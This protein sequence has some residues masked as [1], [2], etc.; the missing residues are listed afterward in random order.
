MAINKKKLE[1]ATALLSKYYGIPRAEDLLSTQALQSMTGKSASGGGKEVDKLVNTLLANFMNS[2]SGALTTKSLI[3][4]LNE[5]VKDNEEAKNRLND[6][7]EIYYKEEDLIDGTTTKL[8]DAAKPLRLPINQILKSEGLDGINTNP[9]SKDDTNLSVILSNSHRLSLTNKDI[10]PAVIFLNGI[11]SVELARAVPFVKVE[12]LFPRPPIGEG[13]RIQTLSLVKFLEGSAKVDSDSSVL[14]KMVNSARIDKQNSNTGEIETYSLAG[15]EL[16]TTPQTMVNANISSD[17]ELHSAQILDKFRPLMTLQSFDVT[18]QPSTGLM[19]FKSADLKFVLH[20]RSRL[21]EI[22]EFVRP[23]LY[24]KTEIQIE[25]GWSYPAGTNSPYGDLINGLRTTEKFA[26][27]NS[28]F[29]FDDVGQVNVTLK[30]AMKGAVDFNNESIATSHNDSYGTMIAGIEELQKIVG[31][32]KERIFN[33]TDS[34]RSKEIRGVQILDLAQDALSQVNFNKEVKG[35]L[36]AF[37]KELKKSKNPSAQKLI[38]TL[39]KIFGEKG[40]IVELRKTIQDGINNKIVKLQATGTDPF[41][42]TE[43]SAEKKRGKSGARNVQTAT[44]RDKRAEAAYKNKYKLPKGITTGTQVSLAKIILSFMSEPLISTKKFDEVQFVFYPFNEHAG[45]AGDLNI[46]NFSVNLEYFTQEFQK[47]RLNHVSKSGKLNLREFLDFLAD[48]V[49]DDPA[50]PSYGLHDEKGSLYKTV[51]NEDGTERSVQM[52]DNPADY[53]TRLEKILVNHGGTFK[54]PQVD[55]YIESLTELTG[56][57]EGSDDLENTGLTI[58]RI[59]IF[60]RHSTSYNSLGTLLAAARESEIEALN[61]A[62]GGKFLIGNDG[63]VAEKEKYAKEIIQAASN[64]SLI[65]PIYDSKNSEI[66]SYRIKGGPRELKKFIMEHMPYII[67]GTGGTTVKAAN[68]S[69]I[70]D[71]Q[72]ST[73]NLLRSFNKSEIQPNGENPGGLPMRII[74]TELTMTTFGNPL[75]NFA[76]QFFIDFQTGTTA[77]A[78]YAVTGLTHRFAPGEFTSEI[79]F[80]PLDGWGRYMSLIE[81]VR[82]AKAILEDTEKQAKLPTTETS[83]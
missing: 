31:D 35:E 52:V 28:S 37:T 25:Y 66:I 41:L 13:N 46:G 40:K 74:P 2:S 34:S 24:G 7:F 53:Q 22:A 75:I 69:S 48:V 59:H 72:L 83:V 63:V 80:S 61:N 11:P 58:L 23:D 73:I 6:I 4:K 17:P 36:K 15:M 70:Q 60:D 50:A 67:Y 81:K 57:E 30:L 33:K 27:I 21:S 39:E 78:I 9:P 47:H 20:D 71:S 62:S 54:M 76:Q 56:V 79:K 45:L 10:D 32:H 16:F 51:F 68:L 42:I 65:E 77:D 29:T 44:G 55:F 5:V 64:S 18:V 26:V 82:Q 38:E 12:F 8:D 3:K 1:A 43:A 19:S 49:I 14:G